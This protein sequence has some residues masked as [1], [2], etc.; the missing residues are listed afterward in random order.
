MIPYSA[1]PHPASGLTNVQLGMW[2]FVA[3]QTMLSAS[4]ISSHVLL[5]AGANGSPAALGELVTAGTWASSVLLVA[6]WAALPR[7]NDASSPAVRVRLAAASACAMLFVL[8]RGVDA[9]WALATGKP[10]S[11][12]VVIGSWFV[13]AGLHV[14]YVVCAAGASAWLAFGTGHSGDGDEGARLR[15]RL[16][17]L[18]I[19]WGFVVILW[20]AILVTLAVS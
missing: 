10:P 19:Y 6:A 3:V 7:A 1:A 16:S 15:Q 8:W 13:L 9:Q 12:H 14:V 2:L 20:F 18:R 11:A 5:S 17:G 4:L